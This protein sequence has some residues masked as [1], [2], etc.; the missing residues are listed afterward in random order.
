MLVDCRPDGVYRG[1]EPSGACL[2]NNEGCG[3][4]PKGGISLLGPRKGLEPA[5][6]EWELELEEGGL[7]ATKRFNS[8]M[9]T[10]NISTHPAM[11]RLPL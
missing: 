9:G 10:G 4:L 8:Y 3:C 5:R 1:R 2:A 7:N 6:K 11:V